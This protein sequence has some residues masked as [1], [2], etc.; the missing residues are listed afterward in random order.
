MET[1]II[2]S[3]EESTED[4]IF[5]KP[6]LR[7]PTYPNDLDGT[8]LQKLDSSSLMPNRTQKQQKKSVCTHMEKIK[9][10]WMG[11]VL[12]VH[13][14]EG[15]FEA[16]LEDSQGIK[17]IVEF[18]IDTELKQD[19]F[20]G[21]R[22]VFSVFTRYGQSSPETANRIE[23]IPPHIWTKKEKEEAKEIYKKLFPE[24]PPL[25]D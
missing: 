4:S 15:Y 6:L 11:A 19:V 21:A 13:D 5:K 22:F 25:E 23:F 14:K 7:L 10:W 20:P 9:E 17:S 18:D 12:E 1:S 2:T 8:D 16:R 24:D 3:L